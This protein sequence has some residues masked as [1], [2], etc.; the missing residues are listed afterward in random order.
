MSAVPVSEARAALR[1]LIETS[2]TEAVF[3]ERHGETRAVLISSAQYEKLM[4][5]WEEIQDMHAFDEALA[6]EGA[7]LDW[8]QAK[9]DLGW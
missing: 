8:E 9:A 3:L 5:A 2:Q 4:D 6:E 1:E 7:N